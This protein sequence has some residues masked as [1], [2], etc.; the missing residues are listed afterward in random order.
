MIKTLV[1]YSVLFCSL[2]VYAGS[3]ETVLRQCTTVGDALSEVQILADKKNNQTIRIVEMDRSS[4]RFQMISEYDD[5][6]KTNKT[7]IASED[8]D[9]A[10]GGRVPNSV[11][12]EMNVDKRTATLAYQG[13]IFFLNCE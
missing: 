2:S 3:R 6:A 11:M 12:L 13:A 8:L 7:Y 4:R 9:S 10:V 1:L 5:K